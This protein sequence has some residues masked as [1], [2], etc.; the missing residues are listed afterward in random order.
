MLKI[1]PIVVADNESKRMLP[2]GYKSYG[3]RWFV[4][5]SVLI[6]NISNYAHW[7]AFASVQS[8]AA[9]FYRLDHLG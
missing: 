1:F 7:I 8:K 5:L 9:E 2:C 6:L 4:L 3:R